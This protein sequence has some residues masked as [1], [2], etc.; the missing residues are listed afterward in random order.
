MLIS[1]QLSDAGTNICWPEF[2]PQITGKEIDNNNIDDYVNGGDNNDDGDDDDV[3]DDDND[4]DD[5]GD[6]VTWRRWSSWIC[7]SQSICQTVPCN[8]F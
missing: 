1:L 6:H 7:D 2:V 4:D 5:I 8:M 3:D